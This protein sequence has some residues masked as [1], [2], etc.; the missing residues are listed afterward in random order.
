M[1]G[2]SI[3]FLMGIFSM[4]TGK[5]GRNMDKDR[6]SLLMGPNLMEIGIMISQLEL[7]DYYIVMEMY[8]KALFHVEL[9][10]EKEYI[11]I[12]ILILDIKDSGIKISQVGMDSFIS[13]QETYMKEK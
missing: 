4:D 10:K 1:V 7:G 6:Y 13:P 8:M 9:K 11:Y 12:R 2:D 5:M 3:H